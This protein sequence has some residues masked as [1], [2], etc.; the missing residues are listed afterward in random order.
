MVTHDEFIQR[1]ACGAD[2]WQEFAETYPDAPGY[3]QLSRVGF[4]STLG[5]ALVYV[6]CTFGF[7]A[8]EGR[9]YALQ[10]SDSGWR[11]TYEVTDGRT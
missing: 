4:D 2:G 5:Q 6:S 10:S 1:Y 9:Y 7:S 8:A 3:L 11:M